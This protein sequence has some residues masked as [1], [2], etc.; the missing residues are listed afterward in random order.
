MET[1]EEDPKEEPIKEI[2]EVKAQGLLNL[3]GRPE[4]W[5]VCT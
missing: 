1:E 2:K 5:A 4:C 3:Q